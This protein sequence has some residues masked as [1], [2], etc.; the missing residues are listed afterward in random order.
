MKR[1]LLSI[2]ALMSLIVVMSMIYAN[3]KRLSPTP[4]ILIYE[5]GGHTFEQGN[6]S[7]PQHRNIV[8]MAPKGRRA[9][10]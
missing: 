5:P 9:L 10:D 7:C 8:T 4:F 2:T 1:I 3:E 6:A